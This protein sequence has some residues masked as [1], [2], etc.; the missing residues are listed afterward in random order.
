MATAEFSVFAGMTQFNP[1]GQGLWIPL[2]SRG[3]LGGAGLTRLGL[4]STTAA[5]LFYRRENKG[6]AVGK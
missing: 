5:A 3:E 6:P 2:G 1:S 4:C